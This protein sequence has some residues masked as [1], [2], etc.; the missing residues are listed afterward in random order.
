MAYSEGFFSGLFEGDHLARGKWVRG[1]CGCDYVGKVVG[2]VSHLARLGGTT[3]PAR[4][5]L[6]D[7]V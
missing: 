7:G 3:L 4:G 2:A 1:Y 5:A 6:S